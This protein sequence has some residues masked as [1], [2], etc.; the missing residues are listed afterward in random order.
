MGVWQRTAGARLKALRNT[1]LRRKYDD[2][3]PG[4]RDDDVAGSTYAIQSHMLSKSLGDEADLARVKARLNN[5]GL[6]MFLDFVPNHLALDNPWTLSHPD[7]FVQGSKSAVRKHLDWFFSPDGKTYLAHGRDPYFPP[8][9]D[10]VQVNFFSR[11]MRQTLVAE[12]L[13]IAEVA[14]GVRCDMAMLALNDVFEWVWGEVIA[15]YHRPETEFW[16]DAIDIVK[17]RYPDFVFLAEAY[18]GLEQ[19]LLDMG[20]DFVYDKT[21]YDRL[22]FSLPSD[23]RSYIAAGDLPRER[24]MHFIENHDEPRAATVFGR[25]RSLAAAVV[26]ATVP[27]LRLFHDG[28]FECKRI[29]LPLQLVREPLED[30]DDEVLRFYSRLLT[31]CNDPAFHEGEWRLIETSQ[32]WE[33]NASHQNL[34]AWSWRYSN[35]LK[36]VVINYA[37]YQS[38][39][40]LKL[41]VQLE[42]GARVAYLDEVARVKYEGNSDEINEQGL[43][44]DLGSWRSHILD[45]PI[46]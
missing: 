40:R 9:D 38:Q 20:F 14:D 34:L 41:P 3:L 45:L 11:E 6:G 8:W 43:Y 33:G 5:N 42:S 32:A 18:W 46:V 16:A 7:W 13:K 17:G 44:V 23:I 37:S 30:I 26:I 29:H 4:W 28:Q 39:G 35:W 2:V 31:I 10:T 12:L 24:T 1:D 27:G 21:L 22:R 36:I 25:E 15:D 19:K